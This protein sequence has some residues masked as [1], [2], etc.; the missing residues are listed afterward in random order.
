M[1]AMATTSKALKQMSA[2]KIG[3]SPSEFWLHSLIA[4]QLLASGIVFTHEQSLG[5]HGVIDFH[6]SDF[7]GIEV[8]SRPT[9]STLI[10]QQIERYAQHRDIHSLILVTVY[11]VNHVFG[12]EVNG[13]PFEIINLSQLNG[14]SL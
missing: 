14:V 5:D 11:S 7:V 13:K 10:I 4:D 3:R 6:T 2:A 9:N 12:S 8:K 1:K